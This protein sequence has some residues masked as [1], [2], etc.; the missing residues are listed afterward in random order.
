MNLVHSVSRAVVVGVLPFGLGR[1]FDSEAA[2]ELDATMELQVG[3][4]RFALRIA[5]GRCAVRRGAAPESGAQM[6]VSA[7]DIV[8]LVTGS[9]QWP[10][11]LAAKRLELSGDPFLA[12]RFPTLFG[13]GG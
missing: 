11:L 6:R 9:V 5:G 1:R 8:R 2:G 4:A 3:E 13:F 7:G 10:Q 12:L